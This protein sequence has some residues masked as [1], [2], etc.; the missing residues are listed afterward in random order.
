[1]NVYAEAERGPFAPL[2]PFIPPSSSF[3]NMKG[4]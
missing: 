3:V 1:V 2:L 4:Y